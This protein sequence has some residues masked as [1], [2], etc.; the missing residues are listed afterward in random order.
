[1]SRRPWSWIA[2]WAVVSL[3]CS[4]PL[5]P[6]AVTPTPDVGLI[7]S[8]RQR[9]PASADPAA[10]ATLTEGQRAFAF[11][12]YQALRTED[13]NLIFSPYSVAGAFALAQVG[14]R[15][16]TEAEIA[17]VFHFPN[18]AA[19]HTALSALDQDLSAPAPT[20]QPDPSGTPQPDQSFQLRVAN[21][22]WG[23][24]GYH[25][26]QAYLDQLA[27]YYGAGL[28]TV[29]FA[30]SAA[31]AREINR[32]VAEQTAD[33][34]TD[35]VPPGQLSPDSRLALTNAIYFKGGWAN[36][37][38]PLPDPLDFTTEAGDHV[39]APG[40]GR[41]DTY[42]YASIDGVQVLELPYAGGRISFVALVPDPGQLAALEDRLT[43]TWFDATLAGMV[44]TEVT[45]SMPK[46]DYESRFGLASA[47][48]ALGL[49]AP[50]DPARADFSGIDGTR[51]LYISAVIHQANITLDETGTEA[52]AATALIMEAGAMPV[53]TEPLALTIDRPY[54]YV[55]RDRETG[56]IL[57]VGRVLDPTR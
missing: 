31:A 24:Q 56:V 10:I 53:T 20:P 17:A 38:I 44:G 6:G 30:D 57:F 4:L 48:G 54:V 2:V 52:A 50:F 29:D 51:D 18:G 37:F 28:R 45:V 3:S 34:I 25:F 55:I 46:L 15:G 35:L 13:G 27:E 42:P 47:L 23:Q 21:A 16:D 19:L 22:A 1:M 49:E 26:E 41:T 14:A 32:W 12:L 39:E 8:E 11:D 5:Q 7:R 33:R 36:E 43:Q 9:L 40:I